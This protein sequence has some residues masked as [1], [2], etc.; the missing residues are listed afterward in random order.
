MKSI[1]VTGKGLIK[2]HPDMTRILITLDGLYS[3]Y[4]KTLKHSSKDITALVL[5]PSGRL[6]FSEGLPRAIRRKK[7]LTGLQIFTENCDSQIR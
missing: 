4:E 2:V 3:E 7:R 5:I 6:S 1:R